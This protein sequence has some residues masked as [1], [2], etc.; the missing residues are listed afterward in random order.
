MPA[1]RPLLFK[2][3]EELQGKIDAYFDY[4]DNYT[5]TVSKFVKE[6]EPESQKMIEVLKEFEVN[7]PK[8]YTL[9][10]LAVFLK[11]DR[12]T[13][14]NYGRTEE[15]FSTIRQAKERIL[16][17]LEESLISNEGNAQGQIF[18]LKNGFGFVD[19]QEVAH[20][21]KNIGDELNE[22]Q[23]GKAKLIDNGTRPETGGQR[24]ESGTPVQDK[25]QERVQDDFHKESSSS[26]LQSKQG[27]QEHNIEE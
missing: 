19:R 12:A 4:C 26:P 2:S 25:T 14:A 24:L 7:A 3:P 23:T 10:G 5:K 18:V 27:E 1:G 20:I 6:V 13:L 9:S 16:C 11:C 21:D 17:Q 15:Y 8:R 22:L